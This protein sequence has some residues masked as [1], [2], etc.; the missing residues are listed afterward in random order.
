VVA[1]TP[2]RPRLSAIRAELDAATL[3]DEM[4]AL[5]AELFPICRS[6]TG[7][8]VRA[9]L[10]RVADEVPL[11]IHEVPSGTRVLDWTVP[12]EWNIREAWI[13]DATG[14]RVVDFATNNLHVV[15]YSEPVRTR[16]SRAELAERVFTLPDRPTLVPYRTAYY[17]PTW[18]FCTTAEQLAALPDGDYEVVIDSTLA[19]GSLTYA[20][21]VVP[22]A[23][24]DEVLLSCH[25]CHPSLANDNL[26]GLA[27]ATTAARI[28]G[29][30]DLRYTYRFLFIPGTIG[31]I[32]W[33]ARNEDAVAR[34]RHG[35]VLSGLGDRGAFTYKRSRRGDTVIDRAVEHVL[36]TEPG[37]GHRVI[38]FS[39]WG[40]DERQFCS[41]GYDLPVGRL[42]RTP[43]GE[44][45]EYHTSADD[46]DFVTPSSLAGSLATVLAVFD[47]L[48][49]DA[50]YCNTNPK[51][52]PQLGRRGLYTAIGGN[53]DRRSTEMAMLWVLNLSDGS[54]SLLDVA[55]RA[56]LPFD[57]VS[58]AAELLLSRGLLQPR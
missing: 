22:G 38:D 29:A 34:V 33:L 51:G 20:E 41:P 27:V 19:D 31:S 54:H 46:L 1:G 58:T 11:E 7:D 18:G 53:F 4:H 17:E 50:T 6:I 57:A 13:K 44:Y 35:L 40:Y 16:L 9:T 10:R 5:V 28:L 39:P 55:R 32:A 21:C 43:H 37:E 24:S 47:V 25:V 12:P 45:P 15:N 56:R 23:E 42:G 49:R 14:K 48:E 26:S 30:L 3:G 8:G 52:E 2:A 36:D